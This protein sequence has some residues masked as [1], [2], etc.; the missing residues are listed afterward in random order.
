MTAHKESRTKMGWSDRRKES[1]EPFEGEEKAV[2]SFRYTCSRKSSKVQ[3]WKI[4]VPTGESMLTTV[5]GL[6]IP[7][8]ITPYLWFSISPEPPLL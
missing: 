4:G 5:V 6:L 3:G 7:V 1:L 2:D 8:P